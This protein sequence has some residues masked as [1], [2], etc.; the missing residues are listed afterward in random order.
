MYNVLT[1]VSSRVDKK[2]DSLLPENNFYNLVSVPKIVIWV[3]NRKQSH[4]IPRYRYIVY[5]IVASKYFFYTAVTIQL[6]IQRSK[7]N[8]IDPFIGTFNIYSILR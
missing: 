8:K 1:N 7:L 4:I 3:L 2:G 5:Y 6:L